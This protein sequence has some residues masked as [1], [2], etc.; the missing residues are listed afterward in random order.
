MARIDGRLE[1]WAQTYDQIECRQ[2][3]R[4]FAVGFSAV[5]NCIYRPNILYLP[6]AQEEIEAVCAQEKAI[7]YAINHTSENDPNVGMAAVSRE[8]SLRT[9][10][11]NINVLAK[12]PLLEGGRLNPIPALTVAMG[13]IPVHRKKDNPGADPRQIKAAGDR[14]SEVAARALNRGEDLAVFPEGTC[15]DGDPRQLQMVNTGMAHI[16]HLAMEL[17]LAEDPDAAPGF[18]F[19]PVGISY[20]VEPFP[21]RPWPEFRRGRHASVCFG[22]PIAELQ[23]KPFQTTRIIKAGMQAVLAAAHENYYERRGSSLDEAEEWPVAA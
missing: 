6:G 17:S 11:G 2:Q 21:R 4:R 22:N 3:S 9:H 20:G 15:N 16:A 10:V 19:L 12:A 5:L 13:G 1:H 18:V 7:V 14:M 23:G 8:P